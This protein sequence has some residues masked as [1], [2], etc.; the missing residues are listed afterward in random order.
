MVIFSKPRLVI[1]FLTLIFLTCATSPTFV[2][3]ASKPQ[4]TDNVVS[5]LQNVSVQLNGYVNPGGL[6]TSYRFRYGTSTS[7]GKI[8]GPSDIGS[9]TN[10][11]NVNAGLFLLSPNTTY[12]YRLEASNSAGTTYGDARSFRTYSSPQNNAKPTITTGAVYKVTSASGV[13]SGTINPNGDNTTW[14]FK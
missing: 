4:V 5:K 9:G 1:L 7:Y 13:L 14:F 10:W 8:A 11:I 6:N 3:A 2:T 12:Y